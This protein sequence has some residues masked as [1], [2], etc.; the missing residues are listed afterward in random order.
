[1]IRTVIA[2]TFFL[3]DADLIELRLQ[4]LRCSWLKVERSWKTFTNIHKEFFQVII[5]KWNLRGAV[6]SRGLRRN[7]WIAPAGPGGLLF[8]SRVGCHLFWTI[9][10]IRSEKLT[11]ENEIIYFYIIEVKIRNSQTNRQK[12]KFFETINR[13]VWIFSSS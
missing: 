12:D 7:C 8:K 3:S 11:N 10:K 1:M 5:N 9:E 2:H 4:N 6:W 13:C